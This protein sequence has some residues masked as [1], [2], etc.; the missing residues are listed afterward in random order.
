MAAVQAYRELSDRDLLERFT[1]ARDEAAFAQDVATRGRWRLAASCVTSATPL[2]R[3]KPG[4]TL[5][6]RLSM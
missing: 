1:G 6:R 5:A 2:P 4:P 3:A